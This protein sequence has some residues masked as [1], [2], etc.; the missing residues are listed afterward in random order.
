MT[1]V[2]LLNAIKQF[3]DSLLA[4][5]VTTVPEVHLGYLPQ[6]TAQSIKDPIYPCIVVRVLEGE[7]TAE[8]NQVTIRLLFS[9]TSIEDDGFLETLNLMERVKNALLNQRVLDG[10][11]EIDYPYK[12]KFFEEQAQPEWFGE[13]IV[14][15]SLPQFLS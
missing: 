1:T 6:K 9:T 3:L 10:R 11:F 8:N 13:A 14:K 15:F 12:W 2:L 5:N 7:E 4:D